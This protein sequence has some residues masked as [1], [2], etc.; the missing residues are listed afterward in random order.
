MTAL[1]FT[2]D[3]ST[4][5]HNFDV[6][7]KLVAAGLRV[8]AC[9]NTKRPAPGVGSW[10][11]TATSD[12]EVIARMWAHN[13]DYLV[14]LHLGSAH[15]L[16]VDAD[17]R[18]G[19]WAFRAF[20]AARGISLKG[21]P[22]VYTPSGGAH[23]FFRQREGDRLGNGRGALPPKS[24]FNVDVRGAVG[25]TIAPGT[26]KWDDAIAD[27]YSIEGGD[28]LAILNAPELPDALRDVLLG[29]PSNDNIHA[30][31]E[32]G[33]AA[34]R[35]HFARDFDELL[36]DLAEMGEHGPR[37]ARL[38]AVARLAGRHVAGPARFDRG[39]AEKR[40]FDAAT[41]N[42]LVE[43]FGVQCVEATIRA[44]FDE[45]ESEP[46]DY[47]GP[48]TCSAPE[49][50]EAF[51]RKAP[52]PE[53]E[54]RVS[55]K[56]T[57]LPTIS[58]ALAGGVEPIT[59]EHPRVRAYVEQAVHD[60]ISKLANTGEGGRNNQLNAS[61]FALYQ[62]VGAGL[63]SDHEAHLKLVAAADACGLIRS[64][65]RSSVLKT[66]AS[67]H[68]AG[69]AQPRKIVEE[70]EA[71]EERARIN[72]AEQARML[73]RLDDGSLADAETGE[74][75]GETPPDPR[76]DEMPDHLTRPGGLLDEIVEWIVAS[77]EY[78]SR[79]LALSAAIAVLGTVI[80]R[81]VAGPTGSD[82]SIYALNVAPT[83]AGKS[84]P[85]QCA[86]S[87]I[88][89]V[90]SKLLGPSDF[91]SCYAIESHLADKPL[92]LCIMDE[93]GSFLAKVT[94]QR[95]NS[96]QQEI[97]K[98]LRRAWD[99]FAEYSGLQRVDKVAP[100]MKWP[101]LSLIGSSTPGEMFDALSSKSATDGFLNRFLIFQTAV[102]GRSARP[103][104]DKR[105][106]PEEI[107]YWLKNLYDQCRGDQY[108]VDFGEQPLAEL[109]ENDQIQLTWAD[110]VVADAFDDL[111]EKMVDRIDEDDCGPLFS[112][113]AEYTVRLATICAV[114][115]DGLEARVTAADLDWG[116]GVAL[117]S[118]ERMAREAELRIADNLAQAQAKEVL[119][120]IVGARRPISHSELLLKL[121]HKFRA[122]DLKEIL[123]SLREAGDV[124]EETVSTSGRPRKV[125]RRGR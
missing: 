20:C 11:T 41:I 8:F 60:E 66:I 117:W 26:I 7:C 74:I 14:G 99:A 6:A 34:L 59:I 118:A 75:V 88:S 116:A 92:S 106:P 101:A 43:D 4:L 98:V 77:S 108:G 47:G 32:A 124:I 85:Q 38:R 22:T 95:S 35:D 121:K 39:L 89:A 23:H 120:A 122:R 68:R 58:P 61:A 71:E 119:R 19:L 21:V 57:P 16:V 44:A 114:S 3:P 53:E 100:S 45:G 24:V 94:H 107:V 79:V 2:F 49:A 28:P 17:G 67:G 105:R 40:L 50:A 123:D 109:N 54:P 102:K 83:G 42:E 76:D 33:R 5:L 48:A 37:A 112:R 15:F 31:D 72:G 113:T 18:A 13:P 111:R 80:G 25:Y 84:A 90:E 70:F 82:T 12:P 63:L 1:D 81:R 64:D 56:P 51:E 87:L 104:A 78:P 69:L 103:T 97:T 62:F 125:Y 93:F 29:K 9:D 96:Y 52:E 55:V 65:G 91:T 73:M 10:P 110:D 27:A 115:R 46:F 36:D 30:L 86:H